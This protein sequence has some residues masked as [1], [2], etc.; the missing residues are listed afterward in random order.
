[1][2]DSLISEGHGSILKNSGKN[3]NENEWNKYVTEFSLVVPRSHVLTMY[4]WVF[5]ISSCHL[6]IPTTTYGLRAIHSEASRLLSKSWRKLGK[7]PATCRNQ[8]SV[9]HLLRVKSVKFWYPFTIKLTFGPFL[10][11][12]SAASR[13]K[14][15]RRLCQQG[16][17]TVET[18]REWKILLEISSSSD[19][20][21][22]NSVTKRAR[23]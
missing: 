18:S 12:N 7:C 13:I 20:F 19:D 6:S 14:W 9:N 22:S 2:I 11:L 15:T 10:K 1:M 8:L 5:L 21:Y 4:F 16:F 17:M 23:K 3:C